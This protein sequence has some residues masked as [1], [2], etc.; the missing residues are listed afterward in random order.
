MDLNKVMIIGRLVRDPELR[1]TGTG[2]TVASFSVATNFTWKDQSGAQQSRV[3]YHNIV[4]WRRLAEIV[5]QYL[6][7]GRQI[8]VEGRLQTRSWDDQQG[9]KKYRTEV[10]ADNMI[11]LGPGGGAGAGEGGGAGTGATAGISSSA[12]TAVSGGAVADT[13]TGAASESSGPTSGPAPDE[14]IR[15]EDIPF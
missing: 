5:G 14:E 15:I 11:M 1:T 7:K 6:K 8:Y 4:A 12:G 3:E 9:Q 2:Q 13:P 10:V